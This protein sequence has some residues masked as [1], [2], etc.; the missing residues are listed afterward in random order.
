MSEEIYHMLIQAEEDSS[1]AKINHLR[2]QVNRASSQVRLIRS[3]MQRLDQLRHRE[4]M[5]G[6]QAMLYHIEMRMNILE[7]ISE[8]Y[9]QYAVIKYTELVLQAM[10]GGGDSE[11]D[12]SDDDDE[13][14][15][16][17]Y[18]EYTTDDSM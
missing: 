17:F 2:N 14:S 1:N 10:F 11:D 16:S 9:V 4:Q 8:T 7:A 13:D 6:R 5:V 3:Q 15:D 12:S 18:Y